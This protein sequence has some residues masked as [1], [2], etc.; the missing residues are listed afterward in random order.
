[1]LLPNPRGEKAAPG[2]HSRPLAIAVSAVIAEK[3]S[4]MQEQHVRVEQGS[5]AAP[6]A[7]AGAGPAAGGKRPLAAYVIIERKG[8]DRPFWSR[9]GSAFFNRDGSINV[10][11]DSLPL[12]GK[13]QL[14]ED[15]P[16]EDRDRGDFRKKPAGDSFADGE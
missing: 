8:Y 9:I 5:G 12:Q 7:G 15:T 11:L 10:L 6:F 4:V 3:G 16:K 1:M 13:I 2:P 14:R